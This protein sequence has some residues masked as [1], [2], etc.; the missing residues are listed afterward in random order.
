MKQI[1]FKDITAILTELVSMNEDAYSAELDRMED[2]QPGIWEFIFGREELNDVETGILAET[3][4][5]GWYI[6]KKVLKRN[7]E[8]SEDY[9]YEQFDRNVLKLSV[10][11]DAENTNDAGFAEEVHSPNNQPALID[12]LFNQIIDVYEDPE[13]PVRAEYLT[14]MMTDL[15][16]MVDCLVIDE[17]TALAEICDKEWSDQGFNEINES[18]KNYYE[19]FKKSPSFMKLGHNEKKEAEFIITGFGEMMY[20][21]FLMRPACWNARRSVECAVDRMPAK[22]MADDSF[23][24][25]I[26]PVLV[27]FMIFCAGKG[28]VPDGEYIAAR[29]E[30][31][32]E[33][34]MEEAE[35][36]ES[37][38]MGK[39]VLKD[40]QSR[41][42]DLSKKK[43]IEAFL[44]EYNKDK[45]IL[46]SQSKNKVEKPGR[47]D[48]CPCGSGKKY[49]KCCGAD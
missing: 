32:T 31:I 11:L 36:E 2:E 19:E 17:E 13:N 48:P 25:A 14:A 43:D 6:I 4:Q 42:Y 12:Y 26:E 35:D 49:K 27:S 8:I 41:G 24:E 18:V 39:S 10:F 47:N 9:L 16:T 34:I 33:R 46:Y 37:W 30:N 38:S 45:E 1:T 20:N 22:V 15:K 21:Y 7:A 5:I 40:A 29:F 23:F 44:K 28:Y 3:A